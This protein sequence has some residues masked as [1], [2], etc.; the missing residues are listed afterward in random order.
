M[1]CYFHP[2]QPGGISV[3]HCVCFKAETRVSLL[4]LYCKWLTLVSVWAKG[5]KILGESSV[6]SFSGK[7][8]ITQKVN[9]LGMQE[10]EACLALTAHV[11]STAPGQAWAALRET[12]N[13]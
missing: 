11:D 3:R 8:G 9:M 1:L 10:R 2:R 12:C 6:L 5:L 13:Y 7:G 4:L